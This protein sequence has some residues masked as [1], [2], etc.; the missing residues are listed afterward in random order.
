VDIIP[1]DHARRLFKACEGAAY[2][3]IRDMAILRLLWDSGGR[4]AEIGGLKVDDV[5]FESNTATVLG[6]GNKVRA[7]PFTATTARA[8]RRYLTMARPRHPDAHYPNLWLGANGR[9]TPDGIRHVLDKRTEKAGLPHIRPHQ[10]RN[11]LAHRFLAAGGNQN[12]LMLLMGWSS[13]QMVSR[14]VASTA[15]ELAHSEYHRLG[16]DDI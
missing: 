6:K 14:Y 8:L 9:M 12:S 11:T 10:F 5:H 7:I 1:A 2:D 3:D 13:P 16:L 4:R 15:T